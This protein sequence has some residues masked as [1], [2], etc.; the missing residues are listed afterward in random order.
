MYYYCIENNQ[1]CAVLNYEPNVPESVSVY[2]IPDEIHERIQK[3]DWWFNLESREAEPLP[4]QISEELN[5][6]K[7][8][9]EK[10]AFLSRTDWQVLRHIRQKA[11]GVPT[12]LEEWQYL[13]LEFQREQTARSIKH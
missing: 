13:D 9:H 8:Y 11:L 12:T 6:D 10:L 5:A 2:E 7:T 3:K 4:A 1:I